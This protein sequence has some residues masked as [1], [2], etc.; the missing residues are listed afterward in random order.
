ML[1]IYLC[2]S[3]ITLEVELNTNCLLVQHT[4]KNFD[5][6]NHHVRNG[7]GKCLLVEFNI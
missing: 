5:Y 3:T 2:E 6:K 1:N 4:V 7:K